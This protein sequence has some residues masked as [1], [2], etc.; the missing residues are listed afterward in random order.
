M[1]DNFSKYVKLYALRSATSK[2]AA[3]KLINDYYELI[4]IFTVLSDHGSQFTSSAWSQQLTTAGIK[5]TFSSTRHPASNSSERVMREL[6][7][8]FRAY[9]SHKNSSWAIHIPRIEELFNMLPHT[10]TGFSLHEI[11]FS[12][13]L[14]LPL[15]HLYTK[16]LPHTLKTQ[17]TREE[18]HDLVRSNLKKQALLRQ[19]H[20]SKNDKLSLNNWVLLRVP[21]TSK[22]AKKIYAK[23]QFLYD[24]P[25][26]I[27]ANPYPN[28]YT[29]TH[30]DT[31]I[32]KGNYN[33]TNLK[34]YI[35]TNETDTLKQLPSD[36]IC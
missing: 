21:A 23:F 7:R 15:D 3:N 12:V 5:Y 29:L 11:I 33:I 13:L 28:V 2:A 27:T 25:F 31:N 32:V 14:H 18:L 4:P 24:G 9:C 6:G 19:K 8:L 10:S 22:A 1:I 30:I 17:R 34:L 35:H 26:K 20:T 16:Y 36:Q